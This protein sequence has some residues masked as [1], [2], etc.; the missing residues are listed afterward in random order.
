VIH[1]GR[2]KM[3]KSTD[4]TSLVNSPLSLSWQYVLS[5]YSNGQIEFFG[6]LLVQVL[7]FWL[8]C[9][10]YQGLDWVFPE[11]SHKHKYQPAGVQPSKQDLWIC[12][13]RVLKN[14]ALSTTLQILLLVAAHF[15]NRPA[16]FDMS[17][18]LPSFGIVARDFIISTML[19]EAMFYYSHRLLHHP[20]LY[21]RIHKMHHKFT[22]PVAL[23]AQYAHFIEHI[24][25]NTLPIV[26]PPAIMGSHIVTFW[27][28][29]GFQL[30]ETSSVHSGFDFF[31]GWAKKHDLHHEKFTIFFGTVGL[32]DWFHETDGRKKNGK[33][34]N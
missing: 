28:F 25:A 12:L 23:A 16:T 27:I 15:A 22:A 29:L 9:A 17:A 24:V 2:I 1:D 3:N 6:T 11:F 34:S 30:I 31:N 19:R 10:I 26:L 21:A 32:L 14:Q 7:C 18:E 20:R 5:S 13:D 8:P 33:K 4:S